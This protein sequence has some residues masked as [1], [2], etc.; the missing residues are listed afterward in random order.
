MTSTVAYVGSLGRNLFL[1][2]VANKILPGFT[3][4]VNGT[5]IPT[6]FGV[7]NRTDATTGQVIGATTV[8]EFSIV[9]GTSVQN[10]YAEVDYKT[11]GGH[12][13][14][15]ALQFSLQRSFATGLT[16]NTQYTFSNST[17]T[18]AGSNE[19]RTSA[20]LDNFEADQ[21]RNNFDV[22]HNFNLSALYMLPIGK[23]KHWDFG[24]AGT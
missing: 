22:H 9:S 19:A 20:Q 15:D 8:R 4:I 17:G 2:S 11:S 16:M 5:N 13:R 12:D 14:Y 18:S 23:G 21:G 3:S 7:V 24:G 10:P 6:G 1:R